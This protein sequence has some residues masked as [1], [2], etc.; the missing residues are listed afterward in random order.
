MTLMKH[1]TGCLIIHGFGGTTSDVEPLSGYLKSKGFITFCPVLKGHTGKKELLDRVSYIEWIKSVE[2]GLNYLKT[3]C[4]DI[5]I[6]GFSMGGLIG[7]NLAVK[8]K[9]LGIV[10]IDTPIYFGDMKNIYYN[11]LI[12]F[13]TGSFNNVKRY[14]KLSSSFPISAL[15]NFRLLIG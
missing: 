7:V 6:I 1:K 10:T 3:K 4:K 13:K 15:I 8:F 12:D 2:N 11:I 14:M 9:F 5:V